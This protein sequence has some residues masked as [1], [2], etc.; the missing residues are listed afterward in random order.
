MSYKVLI[1]DDITENRKLLASIIKKYTDYTI[2]LAAKGQDVL[3]LFKNASLENSLLPDIILMDIIMPELDGFTVAQRLKELP[4]A[5]EIPILFVTALTDTDTIINAFKSGGVDYISKPFKK[6]ELLARLNTHL[7]LMDARKELKKKNILLES[8]KELLSNMVDEKTSQLEKLNLSM[9]S[10]LENANFYNDN[11]TGHHI[12][13]VSRFA[14]LIAKAS[15]CSTEFTHKIALFASLHDIGKVGVSDSLLKKKSIY[16]KEE[17]EEMK[18]HVDIASKMLSG[19]AV[20]PV[21][22]N[23]AVYH[24]EKWDGSGYTQG[25]MGE[26]IPI[27][28][29]I[30]A[31]VDVYDALTSQRPYKKAFSEET[32]DEMIARE[33]GKHFDPRLVKVFFEVKKQILEI[34]EKNE[35]SP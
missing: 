29:R 25:L 30:V 10:A 13:R 7:N 8:K 35:F 9:V 21:A 18:K 28:A 1:V 27:E 24:H 31:L 23:I 12:K 2:M 16:T 15:G 26:K 19:E 6:E 17:H 34:K 3:D 11:D 14:G 33:S 5:L 4:E 22:R 32:A 20:D